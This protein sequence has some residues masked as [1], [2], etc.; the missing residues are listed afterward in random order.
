MND[1]LLAG[2]F[3]EKAV[4]AEVDA[5]EKAL[6]ENY[7]KRVDI[8]YSLAG[9]GDKDKR[10]RAPLVDEMSRV[11]FEARGMELKLTEL[12]Q[13]LI[14]DRLDKGALN[15]PEVA[16]YNAFKAEH[17]ALVDTLNQA[18]ERMAEITRI[19]PD[20]LDDGQRAALRSEK[21]ALQAQVQALPDEIGESARRL[22]LADFKRI[23]ALL[24]FYSGEIEHLRGELEVINASRRKYRK[25]RTGPSCAESD[26][27]RLTCAGRAAD[28]RAQPLEFALAAADTNKRALE[29]SIAHKYPDL[30]P[31]QA[32]SG[33]QARAAHLFGERAKKA[34]QG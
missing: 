8:G 30:Y 10:Q 14:Q 33:G 25:E 20:V 23:Q 18:R 6:A 4:R 2:E 27:T 13:A 17:A 11:D 28:K 22:A 31:W 32:G 15:G 5:L 1:S 16:A 34:A 24:D 19:L 7:E 29:G 9:V 21:Q 3:D 12:Q 26:R